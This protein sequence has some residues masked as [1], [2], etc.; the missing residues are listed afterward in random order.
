[1]SNTHNDPLLAELQQWVAAMLRGEHPPTMDN[2]DALPVVDR[3]AQT[4]A[5]KL[6]IE[7][8]QS[9]GLPSAE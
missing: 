5:K 7:L 2:V 8:T 1:M 9:L 6:A 4:P 3:R